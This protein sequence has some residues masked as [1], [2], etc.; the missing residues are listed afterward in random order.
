M[1]VQSI[2][3][4]AMLVL[5]L[6]GVS[7][8]SGHYKPR[9]S[10]VGRSGA[11]T[12]LQSDSQS[13]QSSCNSEFERC[14]ETGAAQGPVGRGRLTGIIGAKADCSAKLRSCLKVCRVR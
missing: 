9:D 11:V 2:L 14:S 1:M 10:Y 12:T 6:V 13:C 5:L 3:R 7:A 8:C 4:P